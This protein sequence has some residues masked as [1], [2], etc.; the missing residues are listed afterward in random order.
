VT[1]V[2]ITGANSGIGQA[3]VRALLAAG[4][5][6]VATVRS[7]SAAKEVRDLQ[8]NGTGNGGKLE[9]DFLDVDDPAACA[10]VIDRHRPDV[11][12]NN[13]GSAL[14]GAVVDIDDDDA[15]RQTESLVI[16]PVRLARL[17]AAHQRRRGHGRVVNVSSV[18]SSATL[19][20]TG[21][22]AA[23]KAALDSLT[24]TL[25]LELQ[26]SG[27]EVISIQCGAVATD[28]W[29]GAAEQVLDGDDPP[30]EE[31]RHRWVALT[32][33]VRTHFP[34]AEEVGSVVARAALDAS[35]RRVYRVGF[36]SNLGILS[37]L[38]PKA[39]TDAVTGVLLH[40]GRRPS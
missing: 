23:G 8:R 1:T 19:P 31:A 5:H 28:V 15:R 3:S 40:L 2:L 10:E 6:V 39:L 25:R 24:D 36:G 13:A 27:I 4:A 21:W 20:F 38:L 37:K 16:A 35:P 11:L 32:D 22:Y 14:L 9:V 29:E 17:A 26:P 30:T 18:L 34:E 12:V 33:A 7:E